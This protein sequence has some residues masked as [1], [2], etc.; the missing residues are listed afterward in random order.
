VG[1]AE[2]SDNFTYYGKSAI[3]ELSEF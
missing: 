1:V 3:G 2:T